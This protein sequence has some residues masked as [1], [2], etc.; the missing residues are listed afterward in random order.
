MLYS[1]GMAAISVSTAMYFLSS[2]SKA[3]SVGLV[4]MNASYV[5][6]RGCQE[7]QHVHKHALSTHDTCYMQKSMS[8]SL[9]KAAGTAQGRPGIMR[10]I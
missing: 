1:V 6:C 8:S 5:A 7:Q 2:A 4:A 9:R 10:T 3:S